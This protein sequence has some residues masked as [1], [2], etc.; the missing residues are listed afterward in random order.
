[1]RAFVISVVAV[2]IL[3]I[4]S[5]YVLNEWQRS[6]Y[7]TFVSPPNVRLSD[8]EAGHNLVGKDWYSAKEH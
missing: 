6:A 8:E 2:L 4:V 7:Q 5:F 1:M 3:A